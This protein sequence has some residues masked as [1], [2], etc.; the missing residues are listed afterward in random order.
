MSAETGFPAP[1]VAGPAAC[2]NPV[3]LWLREARVPFMTASVVPV[4]LGVAVAVF[5]TGLFD[6]GLFLLTLVG[7]IFA[8]AGANMA[9]DYYD[10]LSGNDGINR[11]RSPFNGGAGLIQAG[12]LTPCQV[13]AAALGAFAVA[14]AIGVYLTYQKGPGVLAL[15]L[16]GGLAAYL[17]SAGPVRLAYRGVGELAVGA[18]FGPLLV[19][20]AYLVQTGT[21]SL[22]AVLASLPVGLLIA[23]VL[24]IN[25]FPDY[26]AD[27]A[28]GKRH[29]VVRLGT[30]RALP[31]LAGLVFGAHL[32]VVG[33][34]VTG[35][36]PWPVLGAL[37]TV[38]MSIKALRIAR[39][40]H[41]SPVEL[42]PA[43]ALVI[44]LHLMAGLLLAAG[45][46]AA[47]WGI[48]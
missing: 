1:R 44:G 10:T 12:L 28:V 20:G 36:A 2:P 21:V 7:A 43:N 45:F 32:A 8:H 33:A 31:V 41:A 17:Y 26:E 42:R 18:S 23:A 3:A 5:E 30:E 14:L 38:P 19:I 48:C 15:A 40:H 16:A 25:Q 11:Y 34:V 47:A 29:W 9:N 39:A 27:K 22:A 46:L 4:V 35:H 24:Y 6:F 37:L 13:H